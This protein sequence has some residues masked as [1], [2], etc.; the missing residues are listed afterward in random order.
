MSVSSALCLVG[1]TLT[2]VWGTRHKTPQ[3]YYVKPTLQQFIIYCTL[4]YTAGPYCLVLYINT[5][6]LSG[7]SQE[8]KRMKM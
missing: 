8:D 2:S 6:V 1:D 5:F 3:L 7:D 4:S